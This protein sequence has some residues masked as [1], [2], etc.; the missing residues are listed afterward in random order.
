MKEMKRILGRKDNGQSVPESLDGKVTQDSILE[1]FKECYEEL[2]NAAGS[3]DAMTNIKAKLEN[4]VNE[5]ILDSKQEI[6]KVTS[7]VV[8]EACSR[9]LPG[10]TDVTEG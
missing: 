9:M 4:I 3:D 7:D 6:E 8:K 5:D 1:R 2:Y 10:K